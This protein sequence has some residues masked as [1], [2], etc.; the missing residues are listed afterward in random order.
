MQTLLR[1]IIASRAPQH[2][3]GTFNRRSRCHIPV[4]CSIFVFSACGRACV[5]DAR[6]IALKTNYIILFNDLSVLPVKNSHGLPKLY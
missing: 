3:A 4:L 1:S 6:V 2:A 5:C